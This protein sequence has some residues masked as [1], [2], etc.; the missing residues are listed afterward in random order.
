MGPRA[1][2]EQIERAYIELGLNKSI[3]VQYGIYMSGFQLLLVASAILCLNACTNGT[4]WFPKELKLKH[5]LYRTEK[6]HFVGPAGSGHF[7]TRKL[8]G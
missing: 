3:P 4:S 8:P 2:P 6:G 7:F 1:T 5:E